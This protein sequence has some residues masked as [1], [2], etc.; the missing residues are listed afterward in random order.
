MKTITTL[1]NELFTLDVSENER[2]VEN[3]AEQLNIKRE[4]IMLRRID[5]CPRQH[6]FY[7]DIDFEQVSFLL[8]YYIMFQKQTT[9]LSVRIQ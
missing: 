8:W 3:F 5:I 1:L 2:R 6:M 4:K 7:T 9:N